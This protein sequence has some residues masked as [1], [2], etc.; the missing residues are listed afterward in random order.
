MG[1]IVVLWTVGTRNVYDSS[2]CTRSKRRAELATP[3]SAAV[4]LIF[5]WPLVALSL[6]IY[7]GNQPKFN[8]ESYLLLEFLT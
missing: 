8:F 2:F 7:S 5:D 6:Y 1:G 4:L 3:R